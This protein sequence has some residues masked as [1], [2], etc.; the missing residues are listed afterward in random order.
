M[1]ALGAFL[2]WCTQQGCSL[3]ASGNPRDVLNQLIS[4]VDQQALPATYTADGVT[5]EGTLTPSLLENAV[6]S[7]LYDRSRGWPILSDALAQA[8]TT[9]QAPALLSLSDQYLGRSP[10]GHWDPLVEANAVISCVDR[11]LKAAP[12]TAAELAD[13]AAFQAQ[14]PPWGGSWA[15]T[16]CLGMPKPAKGDRLGDVRVQGTAP[17][18]VIGTTG[19]PATPYAGAEAL[20]G[21]VA[22]SDLLTFDSTEHTAYARGFS[23]CI[24][25]AVDAY[26]VDGTLPA[27]GTHCAPD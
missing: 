5:R 18:L 10:D 6:L 3:A 8:V 2:D 21:R 1:N 14:L 16:Y 27:P 22:G 19:D 11:P 20:A 26:L 15:T 12:T 23:T 7:M 25:D 24:D 9:G 13:V 4:R 17:I